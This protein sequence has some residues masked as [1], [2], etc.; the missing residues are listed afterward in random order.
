VL[1]VLRAHLDVD[2]VYAK[3]FT[4]WKLLAEKR[5]GL[6]APP[7]GV[8]FH[9]YEMF[10]RAASARERLRQWMLRP[11]VRGITRA[12]DFVFSYGSGISRILEGLGVPRERILEVPAGIDP[13]WLQEAPAA[14]G[15]PRRFLYLGRYE[16]RKGVEEIGAVL[17]EMRPDP[18][19]EFHFVGPIPA[20]L[21]VEA[22]HVR[23]HGAVTDTAQLRCLLRGA[24][25]LVCPSYSEGM[26]NVILEAMASGLA[27]IA[28][29]VGAV[30]D[31]VSAGNG[32]LIEPANRDA[33]TGALRDAL[34]LPPHELERRKRASL[35]L[36][37]G[38]H[39]WET[40]APRTIE[41]IGRAAGADRARALAR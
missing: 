23:Y 26:P 31:L 24:D 27:V 35:S 20:D 32:W 5:R 14:P 41:A 29:D 6:R 30:G 18:P 28:T 3:G 7:V 37:R 22:P 13:E 19:F 33:L 15:T 8:N 2:F 4:G 1:D 11:P 9:G 17:R 34:R 40:I 16:R 10:Q 12:A 25:V 36:I 38:G 21:Q 39:S